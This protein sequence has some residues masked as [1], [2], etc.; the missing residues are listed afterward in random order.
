MKE[1]G[2][3]FDLTII[4]DTPHPFLRKQVWFEQMIETADAFFTKHLKKYGIDR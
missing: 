3:Q 2:I 4:K 1:L